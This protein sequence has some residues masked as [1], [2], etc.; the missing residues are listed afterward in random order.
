[1]R[2]KGW[3]LVLNQEISL[4]ISMIAIISLCISSYISTV[5]YYK[6]FMTL[7]FYSFILGK[8]IFKNMYLYL[9]TLNAGINKQNR[10]VG[11]FCFLFW[12]LDRTEKINLI[13]K[14]LKWPLFAKFANLMALKL[15]FFFFCLDLI[16]CVKYL[17]Y[18]RS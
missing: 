9:M 11:H 3:L 6:K 18:Y 12:L 8:T 17:N 4:S 14:T 16:F 10:T 5:C 15:H 7:T 2:E 13:R 1:M